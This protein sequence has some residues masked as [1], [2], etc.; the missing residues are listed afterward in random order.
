LKSTFSRRR[1][2]SAR[3]E[4]P[5]WP[6]P[7]LVA[8]AVLA[9][10]LLVPC[11]SPGDV[12]SSPAEI[13][14]TVAI[15]DPSILGYVRADAGGVQTLVRLAGG[16]RERLREVPGASYF[17]DSLP[18]DMIT[19]TALL[20]REGSYMTVVLLDPETFGGGAALHYVPRTRGSLVDALDADPLY[21]RLS[22][23]PPEFRMI[24]EQDAGREIIRAIESM[25]A[26]RQMGIELDLPGGDHPLRFCVEESDRGVMV[27]PSYDAR[28]DVQAFLESTDYLSPWENA[29]FVIDLD[30]GRLTIAYVDLLRSLDRSI[31]EIAARLD[32]AAG[33]KVPLSDGRILRFWSTTIL[34][35]L[36]GADALRFTSRLP[37]SDGAE[38][39]VLASENG[40]LDSLMRSLRE[41]GP[42]KEVMDRTGVIPGGLI[43]QLNADPSALAGLYPGL[44]DFYSKMLDMERQALEPLEKACMR[45][46][47][48]DS[49]RYLLATGARSQSGWAAC[50]SALNGEADPEAI[51]ERSRDVWTALATLRGRELVAA[52]P[53]AESG[54]TSYEVVPKILYVETGADESYHLT[55]SHF[56]MPGFLGG[57]RSSDEGER[58]EEF[59]NKILRQAGI[60]A[61]PAR[62]LPRRAHLFMRLSMLPMSEGVFPAMGMLLSLDVRG[63]G[64]VE[65]RE[66]FVRFPG[67]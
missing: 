65:G 7:G 49:G 55:M 23:S 52:E 20:A 26:L 21:T 35:L 59:T 50:L 1:D 46:F 30:I 10:I 47:D 62:G 25:G 66:L 64:R 38:L 39:R 40:S 11:C 54:I 32:A 27:V 48:L 43:L 36:G 19:R 17:V 16:L 45:S 53:P 4:R 22:D 34:G 60:G 13:L 33:K 5:L 31:R 63:Y 57:D 15:P 6:L 8:A 58:P 42:E 3:E 41:T 24:R 44:M 9:S 28:R 2:R 37:G 12:R 51:G 56:G 14:E 18:I 61:P 29:G 67:R